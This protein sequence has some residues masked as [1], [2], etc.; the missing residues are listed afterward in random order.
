[1]RRFAFGIVSALCLTP[2]VA[3][4]PAVTLSLQSPGHGAILAPG[5]TVSWSISFGVST[6][7]NSGAAMI[8]V[9][10][11]QDPAN[12]AT[13]DLPPATGI[14]PEMAN[15]NRPAGICNPGEG[16]APS[17]YVGSRRGPAG[18]RNLVQIGGAQNTFGQ[19]FP[20]GSGVGENANVIPAVGL[21][22]SQTLASGSFSA[23]S[24][25]GTYSFSLANPVANVI[26]THNNPPAITRVARAV[27]SLSP[28][29]ISFTVA[30]IGDL[31]LDLDVDIADLSQLLA[32]Y[33]TT[34]GATYSEGDLTGDGNVNL[35]DLTLM[36]ANF[37]TLCP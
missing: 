19:P 4:D 12:P 6:G 5:A 16:G 23:P 15:F 22:G 3:A 21:G 14:P 8:C 34:G 30:P 2:L 7:D 10:L 24:A 17:G 9:D 20:A 1:M 35:D 32:G 18:A 13:F 25:C 33:G 11:V 31:D 29:T 36:L 28:A 37:G 27:S 26:T